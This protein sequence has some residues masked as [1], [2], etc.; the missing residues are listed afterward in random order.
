MS[1]EILSHS[2]DSYKMACNHFARYTTYDYEFSSLYNFLCDTAACS[3][4]ITNFPGDLGTDVPLL[5]SSTLFQTMPLI[6]SSPSR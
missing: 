1:Y 5:S 4:S 2:R 6:D 3:S